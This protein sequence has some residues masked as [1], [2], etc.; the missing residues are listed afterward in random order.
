MEGV[1]KRSSGFDIKIGGDSRV[2]Q[3]DSDIHEISG[4]VRVVAGEFDNM[5][6]AMN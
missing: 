5:G 1:A 4:S 6:W 2:W 3:A